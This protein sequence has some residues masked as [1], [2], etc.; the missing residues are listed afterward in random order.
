MIKKNGIFGEKKCVAA[1]LF[2]LFQLGMP[3][4]RLSSQYVGV[5][6]NKVTLE[7]LSV[8]H[9][10]LVVFRVLGVVVVG[11]RIRLGRLPQ[12]VSK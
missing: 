1:Y 2:G 7:V 10:A 12:L 8:G 9:C 11:I 6:E 3:E 4:R 5:E